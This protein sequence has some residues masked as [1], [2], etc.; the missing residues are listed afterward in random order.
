MGNKIE[1]NKI[2]NCHWDHKYLK[3]ASNSIH[4]DIISVF[5][6]KKRKSFFFCTFLI[7][8]ILTIKGTQSPPSINQ[9]GREILKSVVKVSH[10]ICVVKVDRMLLFITKQCQ[11]NFEQ[12]MNSYYFHRI[13]DGNKRNF[14]IW[15]QIHLQKL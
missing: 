12:K 11:Q 10:F 15:L 8:Y 1:E 4:V 13:S 5:N 6:S 3:N 2:S 14:R 7:K 9:W